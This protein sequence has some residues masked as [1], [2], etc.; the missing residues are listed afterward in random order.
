MVKEEDENYRPYDTLRAIG[1]TE[2]EAKVFLTTVEQA[3]TQLP[4]E[5]QKAPD[6]EVKFR[7][8]KT[9]LR[10]S[11]LE[12]FLIIVSAYAFI[13]WIYVVALQFLHPESLYAPFARWLPIRMDYVGETAFVVSFIIIIAITIPHKT[14]HVN[15]TPGNRH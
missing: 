2:D 10:H 6:I 4:P 7:T 15:P 13:V 12:K 8:E 14:K 1:F 3:A 11:N 9:E 5:P